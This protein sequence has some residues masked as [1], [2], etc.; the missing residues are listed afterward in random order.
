MKKDKERKFKDIVNLLTSSIILILGILL[1]I[2][3]WFGLDNPSILLYVLFA[4]YAGIE[5]IE[6]IIARSKGDN[7]SLYTFIA[8]ALAAISGFKFSS[9]STPKV[10]SITL[11]SW[12]GIMTII[13]L[14]KL[15][16]YHDRNNGMVYVNLVTFS[17]FLLLGILTSVNLYFNQTVQTL[18]LGF[19]FTVNG[20]LQLSEDAIRIISSKRELK[21]K[22]ISE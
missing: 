2:F 9:Y 22:D 5:L 12:I 1:I 6:Y 20:L 17:L 11:M 7:E 14:I 10:L 8:C 21:I 15:D 16:Y 4:I 18:M 13:K 19:F 3:P